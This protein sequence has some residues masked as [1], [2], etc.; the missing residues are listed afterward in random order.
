MK[1]VD[2]AFD[3]KSCCDVTIIS[4]PINSESTAADILSLPPR[5]TTLLRRQPWASGGGVD[6]TTNV[7]SRSTPGKQ[8]LIAYVPNASR[9]SWTAARACYPS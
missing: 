2:G 8:R 7:R 9:V 3:P 4:L 1:F 5:L 6:A